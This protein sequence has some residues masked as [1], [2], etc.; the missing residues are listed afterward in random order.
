MKQYLYVLQFSFHTFIFLLQYLM[1]LIDPGGRCQI[2]R[3]LVCDSC[4]FDLCEPFLYVL[5]TGVKLLLFL[6]ISKFCSLLCRSIC[7]L[8]PFDIQF[9]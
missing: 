8:L 6:C 4:L 1:L 7:K 5:Y 9:L 2:S 3:P